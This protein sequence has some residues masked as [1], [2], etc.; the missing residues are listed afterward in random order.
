MRTACFVISNAV[1]LWSALPDHRRARVYA[2]GVRVCVERI[3]RGRGLRKVRGEEG[4]RDGRLF[5]YGD[6]GGCPVFRMTWLNGIA[7]AHSCPLRRDGRLASRI[8]LPSPSPFHPS[9]RV[10][11]SRVSLVPRLR[12]LA[13]KR[14]VSFSFFLAV[15]ANGAQL[16]S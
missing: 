8:F 5:L 9:T 16:V 13:K 6:R 2:C 14:S 3:A 4:E 7:L 10:L 15:A 11:L 12:T 1:T